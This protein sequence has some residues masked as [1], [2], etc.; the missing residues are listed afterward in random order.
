M[1][2]ASIPDHVRLF[3]RHVGKVLS[4]HRRSLGL[5]GAD[6]S[7]Q[8]GVSL[9]AIRSIETGRVASPGLYVLARISTALGCSLDELARDACAVAG[10]PV[11]GLG[12]E[13]DG[14]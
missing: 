5:S 7:G 6:L 4:E 13:A 9:D 3:G 8:T 11:A 10:V 2:C 14:D 12:A 1:M